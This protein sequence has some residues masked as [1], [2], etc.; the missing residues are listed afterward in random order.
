MIL[1][2]LFVRACSRLTSSSDQ[3]ILFAF[4]RFLLTKARPTIKGLSSKIIPTLLLSSHVGGLFEWNR[5]HFGLMNAPA[6]FQRHMADILR[7]LCDQIVSTY[8]DDLIMFSKSF[9]E[10]V[11]HVTTVLRR[12]RE[13]GIKL[14]G[15]KYER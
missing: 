13:H 8:P 9:T 11:Q 1:L 3:T 10:H 15:Q 6:A 4:S 7:D 14:K 12:L 2:T 5:I